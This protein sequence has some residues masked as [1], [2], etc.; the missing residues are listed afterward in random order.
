MVADLGIIHM[1]DFSDRQ[2]GSA[3]E[4]SKISEETVGGQ[5]VYGNVRVV[6][7]CS[8]RWYMK[9]KLQLISK[10]FGGV[11]T[12]IQKSCRQPLDRAAMGNAVGAGLLMLV[13]DSVQ[14]DT[15]FTVL[16]LYWFGS[17]LFFLSFS[18]GIGILLF[19]VVLSTHFLR[20]E[21]FFLGGGQEAQETRDTTPEKLRE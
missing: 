10:D 20:I 14:G 16:G 6:G 12:F 1:T 3:I 7:T 18:F 15:G 8:Q 11:G 9:P 21:I 5:A 17:L 19:T 2:N 13:Q 4:T